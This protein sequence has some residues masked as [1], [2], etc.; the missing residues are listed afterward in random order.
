MFEYDKDTVYALLEENK[1]FQELYA[2][3]GKLKAR[4][5]D[6]EAGIYPLDRLSLGMLKKEKLLAKDRMAAIIARYHRRN[7]QVGD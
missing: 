7:S 3:H 6:I 4:I 1:R 5:R 2:H